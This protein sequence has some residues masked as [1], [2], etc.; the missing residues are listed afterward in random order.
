MSN[1]AWGWRVSS[2]WGLPRIVV[3]IFSLHL[4][5][6]L[7]AQ[8]FPPEVKKA[9][10]AFV[11][12]CSC[13]HQLSACGMLNCGSAT[14]LRQEIAEHLKKGETQQ[15]IVDAFVSKYGKVILSAP[16]TQGLDLAAW[17]TPFLVLAIGLI[18]V[19]GVIK[20]WVQRR[21]ALAQAGGKTVSI[22]ESY[23]ERMEKEMKDFE[24]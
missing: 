24:P 5:S 18:L 16:T 10:E 9:S 17:V 2:F 19:Y 20:A 8:V 14:P 7:F 15:Q 6:L 1:G 22:P 12:Q 4:P 13:N 11:C 23:R 21:P 3:V